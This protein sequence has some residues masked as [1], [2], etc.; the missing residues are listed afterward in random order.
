MSEKCRTMAKGKRRFMS[1]CGSKPTANS[2]LA[3]DSKN[4]NLFCLHKSGSFALMK[5]NS[6]APKLKYDLACAMILKFSS[7][8]VLTHS[9]SFSKCQQKI[10]SRY[11]SWSLQIR[12]GFTQVVTV[13]AWFEFTPGNG[14]VHDV[15][16]RSSNNDIYF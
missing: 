7:L 6:K 12:L 4:I 10:E 15:I 11:I 8:Y 5:T 9:R 2:F 13:F 3:E 1:R 14:C 16:G